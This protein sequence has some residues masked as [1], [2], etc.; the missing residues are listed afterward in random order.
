[1]AVY[2]P[3]PKCEPRPY[4]D[5]DALRA[6]LKKAQAEGDQNHIDIISLEGWDEVSDGTTVKKVSDLEPT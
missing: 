5:M 6:H 3:V 4:A 2:C 1:V